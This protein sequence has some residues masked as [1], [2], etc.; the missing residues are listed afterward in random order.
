M[1]LTTGEFT[2]EFKYYQFCIESDQK[3]LVEAF[4]KKQ[5]ERAAAGLG[6]GIA[7]ARI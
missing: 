7:L 3:V 1:S 4:K 5:A 2:M 6:G